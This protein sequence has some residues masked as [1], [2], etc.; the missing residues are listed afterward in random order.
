MGRPAISFSSIDMET[1]A[2]ATYNL[3]SNCYLALSTKPRSKIAN[4]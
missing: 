3:S 1:D 4:N 2:S